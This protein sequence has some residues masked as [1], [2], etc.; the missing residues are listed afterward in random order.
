LACFA[1]SPISNVTLFFPNSNSD[2]FV[3]PATGVILL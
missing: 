3:E 2:F 1:N